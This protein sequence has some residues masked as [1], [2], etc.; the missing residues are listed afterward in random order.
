[1]LSVV[2][3]VE[4][5]SHL[6]PFV[7]QREHDGSCTEVSAILDEYIL[8]T[9]SFVTSRLCLRTSDACNGSSRRVSCIWVE[10]CDGY[11][12]IWC[13]SR[14]H[15]LDVVDVVHGQRRSESDGECMA[16]MSEGLGSQFL[17]AKCRRAV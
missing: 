9:H 7:M 10:R 14:G 16:R 8:G 17:Y 1:L 3:R 13:G 15:W 5:G 11:G 6:M 12:W 4:R 2:R